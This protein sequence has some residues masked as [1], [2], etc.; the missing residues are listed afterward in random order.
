MR[1]NSIL[2]SPR[3]VLI[4][5][6]SETNIFRK[7]DYKNVDFDSYVNVDIKKKLYEQINDINKKIENI[8]IICDYRKKKSYE[9]YKS[10]L[11]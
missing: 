3:N 5:N 10:F 11:N 6:K 7:K 8:G 2:I 4:K 1:K 9:S